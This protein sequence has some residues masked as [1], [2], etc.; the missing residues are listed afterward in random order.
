M[1]KVEK[2]HEAFVLG[3]LLPHIQII[4]V[5]TK[6]LTQFFNSLHDSLHSW[7]DLRFLQIKCEAWWEVFF[8]RSAQNLNILKTFHLLLDC[9][10]KSLT[11]QQKNLSFAQ[12]FGEAFSKGVLRLVF[13]IKRR[14]IFQEFR[15][16]LWLLCPFCPSKKK[17]K[18]FRFL[19]M[20]HYHEKRSG[21]SYFNW[22]APQM[23]GND[24]QNI[25][26]FALKME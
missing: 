12:F 15:H 20:L 17:S 2:R 14:C 13:Q 3:L 5:V 9:I 10:F 22:A 21:N 8:D 25:R 26:F 23:K 6:L 7:L 4:I 18:V 24:G 16:F 19:S 11:D 1:L